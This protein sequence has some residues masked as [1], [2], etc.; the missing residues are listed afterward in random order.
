MA[1]GNGWKPF[2]DLDDTIAIP[3]LALLAENREPVVDGYV[4]YHQALDADSPFTG[5]NLPRVTIE[6]AYGPGLSVSGR[7]II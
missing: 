4:A 6:L 3:E 7:D 1:L 2:P 5:P